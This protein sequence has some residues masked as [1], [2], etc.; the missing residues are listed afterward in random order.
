MD[1]NRHWNLHDGPGS[2]HLVHNL[3]NTVKSWISL[4]SAD[5]TGAELVARTS[6]RNTFVL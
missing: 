6:T 5:S 1:A 3:E 4:G 2:H